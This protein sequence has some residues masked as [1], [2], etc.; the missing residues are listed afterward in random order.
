[1]RTWSV[2]VGTA[3]GSSHVRKNLP[4][5]DAHQVHIADGVTVAAVADGHGGD[6]YVRSDRGSRAAVDTAVVVASR[7]WQQR[8][9]A[10]RVDQLAT[11]ATA[12]LVPELVAAWR[13]QVLGDWAANPPTE[14]ENARAGTDISVEPILSYGATLLCVVLSDDVALITQLGD[15]DVFAYQ[16]G[17]LIQP[18]PDDDRLVA[19][20]TTSLCLESAA[21]DFRVAAIP[22]AGLDLVIVATDG[23]GNSFAD[24]DWRERVADDL[25]RQL[26]GRPAAALDPNLDSWVA[27]SADAGGDDVTVAVITRDPAAVTSTSSTPAPSAAPAA[28]PVSSNQ[29]PAPSNGPS[30]GPHRGA[31][32]IAA[33]A[34]VALAAGVV[35]GALLFRGDDGSS[36]DSDA[37]TLP[38]SPATS[39]TVP[40]AALRDDVIQV[41]APDGAVIEF[42]PDVADPRPL[43]TAEPAEGDVSAAVLSLRLT[44]NS[45]WRLNSGALETQSD[46]NGRWTQV[47]LNG[48]NGGSLAYARG[49]VWVIDTTSQTLI[50][51][52]PG[53]RSV[54]G[55]WPVESAGVVPQSS[56]DSTTGSDPERSTETTQR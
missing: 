16:S 46:P 33:A 55:T 51:V 5:Q 7:W 14:E 52:N 38:V 3:R 17:T 21:A 41:L 9:A 36:A 45:G 25:V 42:T 39:S 35:I 47:R 23:Y 28:A 1:V 13:S 48:P 56:P 24:P 18:L 50:A 29:R 12:E 53:D 44:D 8:G 20:V 37:S 26:A 49:T 40:V 4:N 10:L 32:W 19:G 30:A 2:A 11:A 27:D 15:G 34:L 6:R 54:V 43:N 31:V 22:A